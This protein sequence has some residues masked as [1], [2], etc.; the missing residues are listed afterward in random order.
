M[1]NDSESGS[2]TNVDELVQAIEDLIKAE[3][4]GY[5]EIDDAEIIMEY[6]DSKFAQ[7]LKRKDLAK[8]NHQPSPK[9]LYHKI[10]K[11]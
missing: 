8:M 7:G 11:E 2:G 1:K 9:D 5:I 4:K 10:C 6:I 3:Q